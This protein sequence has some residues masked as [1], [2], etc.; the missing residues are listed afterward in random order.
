[1]RCLEDLR[2]RYR[3]VYQRGGDS[4]RKTLRELEKMKTRTDISFHENKLGVHCEILNSGLEMAS[5]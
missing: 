2:R 5:L 1:M 3:K 4:L